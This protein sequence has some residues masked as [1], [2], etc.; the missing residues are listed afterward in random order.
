MKRKRFLSLFIALA[1]CLTSFTAFAADEADSDRLEVYY[2]DMIIEFDVEPIIE[3]GRTLV[4]MRAIF[5][6]MG[7]AVYYSEEDGKQNVFAR[8]ANDSLLLT[9]G[10]NKMYFNNDE[11]DLDVP[12]KIKDGRTLIPLRAVS[13]AFEC[14]VYWYGDTKT[15]QIYSPASAYVNSIEK[16]SE[17]ITDYEGNVL[18]E[19]VAYYPVFE[20]PGSMPC[21]DAIN[22]DYKWDVDKFIEEA[23]AKKDDALSLKEQMGDKFTTFVYELTFEKTYSI[24]GYLSFINHKYINVG[25][26]HPTKTMESRT[27]GTSFEGEMSVSDMI[28]ESMLDVSCLSRYLLL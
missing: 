23:R 22:V 21:L 18:I 28:E 24:W 16:I 4:P 20:N 1:L 2:N 3:D 26:A 9:I 12:A 19:A 11:K 14:E 17:T 8:R 13:E 25:G 15:I 5:E 6:T 10:E 7:C 27:Y